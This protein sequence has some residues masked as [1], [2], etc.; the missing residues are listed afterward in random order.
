MNQ[1][2]F[3]IIWILVLGVFYQAY[4]PGFD[5]LGV[6]TAMRRNISWADLMLL[7]IPITICC[8]TRGDFAD[9]AGYRKTYENFYS[10]YP[11]VQSILEA[12][13]KGPA[14][15]IIQYACRRVL[16]TN[17]TVF[18]GLLAFVQISILLRFYKKYAPNFWIAVFVFIAS[19]D[20]LSWMQN[21]VRQFL[22]VALVLFFADYIFE[23]KYIRM[24]LVIILASTI[25]VSALVMIPIIFIVQ[26]KAWNIKTLLL[27]TVSVAVL[28]ALESVTGVVGELLEETN[29]E[30]SF[31]DWQSSND[32]GVNPIRVLVY[33]IPTILS[34]IGLR[35]VRHENDNV[36]NIACN[37]GVVSTVLYIVAVFTSGI[38]V[39]RLPVYCS[40]FSNGIFLPWILRNAFTRSSYKALVGIMVVA[41]LTFYYYQ[42]HFV[43]GLF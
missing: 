1:Y 7:I 31:A 20:Y 19:T 30:N 6:K 25:H 43:W 8:A 28:S 17:S 22:A 3:I 27:I 37:M 18:L 2:V 32:D 23:R 42:A 24:I 41:Y 10:Y 5:T 9:S 33:S 15:D 39:G 26:G 11:D 16:G 4:Q 12:E 21:G 38:Y 36:I 13:E 14:F 29:Y 34:V 40:L 35:Y